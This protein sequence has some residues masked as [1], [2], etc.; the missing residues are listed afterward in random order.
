MIKIHHSA[1][2]RQIY[3]DEGSRTTAIDLP[4]DIDA[5]ELAYVLQSDT[6]LAIVKALSNKEG[7]P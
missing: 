6:L 7:R 4:P 1:T 2:A 5:T 3:I